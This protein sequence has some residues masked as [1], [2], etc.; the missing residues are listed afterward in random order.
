MHRMASQA[1]TGEETAGPT[2]ADVPNAAEIFNWS[3][4][5]Y[6]ISAAWEAGVL[7]HLQEVGRLEIEAF[8]AANGLDAQIV[9]AMVKALAMGDVVTLDEEAGVAAPGRTFDEA[10]ATKALFHW[11][12]RASGN[13]IGQLGR[14]AKGDRE[15]TER[16]ARAIGIAS[17][18]ANAAY[19]DPV[20]RRLLAD[21]DFDVVADLGS[22]AGQRLIDM[23]LARPGT[24]GIGIELQPRSNE[25]ARAMITAAGCGDRVDILER[26]VTALE[27]EDS[28]ADVDLVTCFLLGH[29]LWP[30]ENAIRTMRSFRE[31]FPRARHLIL[32]DT[33]RT[34]GPYS[35]RGSIFA[36]AFDVVHAGMGQFIP[37]TSDWLDMLPETGWRCLER[38]DF[39]VPSATILFHLVPDDEA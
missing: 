19:F 15:G 33:V 28:F 4:V 30:R 34:E 14:V 13:L 5:S 27:Y 25:N 20:F 8:S 22:G 3:V 29:D 9:H 17:R 1:A 32:C 10:N 18:E 37:T 31:T 26:D 11:L 16:D 23:V 12:H 36:S 39:E 21:I 6:A 38:H 2:I 35:V 24:R 7:E